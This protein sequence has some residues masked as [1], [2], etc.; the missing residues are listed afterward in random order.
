DRARCL[1]RQCAAPAAPPRAR[2]ATTRVGIPGWDRLIGGVVRILILGDYYDL[3]DR[4][5][6]E[7]ATYS[8]GRALAT[9]GNELIACT[10]NPETADYQ[11]VLGALDSGGTDFRL[12][13]YS[14]ARV[15]YP[16]EDQLKDRVSVS[17]EVSPFA[18]WE[19]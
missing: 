3:E 16:F 1:Q 18:D 9:A 12:T 11:F 19:I 7:Q 15:A 14:P 5:S 17:Y 13:I 8:L 10:D 2:R 6:A 4:A